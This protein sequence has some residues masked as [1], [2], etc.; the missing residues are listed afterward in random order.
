MIDD[1][2]ELCC[3]GAPATSSGCAATDRNGS[4]VQ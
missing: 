4:N 3:D 1:P 2:V